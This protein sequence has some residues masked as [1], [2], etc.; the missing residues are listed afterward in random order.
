MTHDTWQSLMLAMCPHAC[1]WYKG[2]MITA[3]AA[4]TGTTAALPKF[5][6]HSG[7]TGPRVHAL[8][9]WAGLAQLLR[10]EQSG[11]KSVSVH[12]D[13][14]EGKNAGRQV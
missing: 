4:A 8:S 1:C 2:S 11:A 5:H 12:E 10:P 7:Q 3:T 14:Q 13:V 9:P 6:L